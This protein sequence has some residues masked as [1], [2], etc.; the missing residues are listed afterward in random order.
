M[1]ALRL[2]DGVRVTARHFDAP[3]AAVWLAILEKWPLTDDGY[4]WITDAYA[5]R[6]SGFHP[7]YRALDVRTR[8]ILGWPEDV[9]GRRQA[10]LGLAHKVAA[11][12]GVDFDVVPHLE[13]AGKP[14]EH[15]HIEYD[16]K[17][18]MGR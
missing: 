13:L 6:D 15:I 5:E 12:L 17:G 16:P 11:R 8:N 7:L 1:L 9:E 18:V 14:Q 4:V 3:F 2:K 10:L